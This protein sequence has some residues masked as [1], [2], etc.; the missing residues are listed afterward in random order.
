MSKDIDLSKPIMPKATAVWLID[1][2]TLTFKQIGDFVELHAIEVQALADGDIG[3][4][5]VGRS[6]IEEGLLTQD[7]ITRCENDAA[8]T[9]K[10]LKSKLPPVKLRSKGP[11]YTPVAKRGD[12]PDAVAYILKHHPE[13]SDAQI[14][15]L[16]GTTKPTIKAIRDRAHANIAN[17]KPRNPVDLGLC[18]YKELDAASAKGHRA[19]GRDPEEEARKRQEAQAAEAASAAEA[20]NQDSGE[21]S[22]EGAFSGFDFSNFM[23]TN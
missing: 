2:T 8:S 6:P 21:S 15:K 7:E 16:V 18:T 3:K 9:L 19:A 20:A 12:K 4:G 13:I 23:K 17:I 11:R 22:R 10:P 14:C 1:N 5:I